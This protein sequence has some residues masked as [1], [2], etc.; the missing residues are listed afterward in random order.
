MY[1]YNDIYIYIYTYIFR[2]HFGSS[3]TLRPAGS[4]SSWPFGLKLS[5]FVRIAALASPLALFLLRGDRSSSGHLEHITG[6]KRLIPDIGGALIAPDSVWA[7]WT[8]I[9]A[10][11]FYSGLR[12]GIP[13]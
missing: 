4:L 13:V 5:L 2:I 12:P 10:V 1:I 11:G 8:L 7:Y 3:R 9:R 6:A